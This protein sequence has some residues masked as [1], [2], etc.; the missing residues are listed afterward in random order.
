[1][2]IYNAMLNSEKV[3]HEVN[4]RLVGLSLS[5]VAG[6]SKEAYTDGRNSGLVLHVVAT[7]GSGFSLGVYDYSPILKGE[8]CTFGVYG[9]M[10]IPGPMN[11]KI[12]ESIKTGVPVM[13]AAQWFIDMLVD[14]NAKA[15]EAFRNNTEV[16]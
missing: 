16:R 15:E 6:I 5:R 8:V 1:M 13:G 4:K 12:Q 7:M 2:K 3:L 14:F 10:W 9:S 11:P